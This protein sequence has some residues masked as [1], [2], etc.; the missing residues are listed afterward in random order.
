M[1]DTAKNEQASHRSAALT[2]ALFFV[3][4]TWYL[5]SRDNARNLS[6][7]MAIMEARLRMTKPN[8]KD[9]ATSEKDDFP[10]TCPDSKTKLFRK[11]F[12]MLISTDRKSTNA[13]L[14]RRMF[15]KVRKRLNRVKT[16]RTEPFPASE[17]S[18]RIPTKVDITDLVATVLGRHILLWTRL[19]G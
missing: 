8:C 4:Q 5:K 14:P 7:I 10:S 3:F 17:V 15:G 12:G 13:R 18:I 9:A 1:V 2:T 16:A 11:T 19:P 6:N